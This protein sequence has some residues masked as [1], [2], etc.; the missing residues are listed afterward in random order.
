MVK[1]FPNLPCFHFQLG[2]MCG[3]VCIRVE[4]GHQTRIFICS[5][6]EG[7]AD[8][9]DSMLADDPQN[10]NGAGY[11]METL[12]IHRKEDILFRNSI[13][14]GKKAFIS[15]RFFA[16]NSPCRF[17]IMV[18]LASCYLILH[19]AQW[20]NREKFMLFGHKCVYYICY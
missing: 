9:N 3:T 12:N 4:S 16:Q 15:F 8:V 19:T 5:T 2:I 13:W 1:Y 7:I 6:I 18:Y 17:I 11:V 14:F 10:W 20:S